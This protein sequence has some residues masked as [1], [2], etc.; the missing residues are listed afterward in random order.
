MLYNVEVY[1]HFYQLLT[2][3]ADCVFVILQLPQDGNDGQL[4]NVFVL[5]LA[6]LPPVGHELLI[7]EVSRSH[8]TTHH[9]RFRLLWT[10]DQLV[11]ET[12]TCKHTTL[13]TDKCPC[14]WWDSN[15]HL[16]R[17]AAADLRLRPRGHW[18]RLPEHVGSQKPPLCSTGNKIVCVVVQF[19]LLPMM[20]NYYN[21]IV[22]HH[23]VFLYSSDWYVTERWHTEW[24]VVFALQK[25][26]AN[27]RHFYVICTSPIM[28]S[29]VS[30]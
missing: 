22:V 11:A 13:N 20:W 16:S 25:C 12:S 6:L 23:S 4:E 2:W 8:S 17:R 19:A 15:P 27:A 30:L 28:L 24:I 18:V 7:H 26:N 14:P 21:S 3:Y 9:S 29:L 5:F 1:V 10:S